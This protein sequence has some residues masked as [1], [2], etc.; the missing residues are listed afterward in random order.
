[1]YFRAMDGVSPWEIVAHRTVWSMVFLAVLLALTPR[2][3]SFAA[4]G[5][6]LRQPRL[7]ALLCLSALLI[8]SNWLVFVWAIDTHH[9]LEASLGYFINPLLNILLG[10]IFLGERLNRA[11]MLA[12]ALACAGVCWRIWQVG[13]LPWIAFYLAITFGFYALI[14]KRA[15]VEA[16]NGLFIETLL[17]TPLALAGLVWLGLHGGLAF[18][19]SV[20]FDLMLPLS[21]VFTAGPLLLF[22]V[23]A[24]HL[25][26]STLGFLQYLSPTISFFVAVLI[27]RE[28]L[29]SAQLT[30]FVC[31]WIALAIYS[32]DMLR[33]KR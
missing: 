32:A 3:G 4:V 21:G 15:P 31:I 11:Q 27:F 12:V 6:A 2:V 23:G 33:Q 7:L 26:L 17:I 25:T 1:M 13:T 5:S 9:L 24:R 22:V 29:D 18:G 19:Q 14:R 16:V 8:T 30:G 10:R 28:T 20:F